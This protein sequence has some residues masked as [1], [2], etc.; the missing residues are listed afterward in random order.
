MKRTS[1]EFLWDITC[2]AKELP[3]ID[4]VMNNTGYYTLAVN[5]EDTEICIDISKSD[6]DNNGIF[7]YAIHIVCDNELDVYWSDWDYTETTDSNELFNKLKEI[8]DNLTEKDFEETG[9]IG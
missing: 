8:R 1:D 6:N 2:H 5:S 3:D 4:S 9:S 7:N